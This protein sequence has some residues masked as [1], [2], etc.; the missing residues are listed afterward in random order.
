LVAIVL[1][2]GICI[3]L[4]AA[5]NACRRAEERANANNQVALTRIAIRKANQQTLVAP[6]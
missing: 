6:S 4:P 5:I 2:V 1:I 3:G